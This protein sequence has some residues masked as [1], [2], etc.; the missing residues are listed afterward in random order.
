MPSDGTHFQLMRR[1][2]RRVEAEEG[3]DATTHRSPGRID[4]YAGRG[5]VRLDCKMRPEMGMR[6]ERV[7]AKPRVVRTRRASGVGTHAVHNR[8]GLRQRK[9]PLVSRKAR[10]Q[11]NAER[12][13][14]TC[15]RSGCSLTG[16]R[17]SRPADGVAPWTV[18]SSTV[19]EG[20]ESTR[21]RSLLGGAGGLI[22]ASN[23]RCSG[24]AHLHGDARLF[25][26]RRG[27]PAMRQEHCQQSR[28]FSGMPE[29]R[30]SHRKAVGD[31]LKKADDA[32]EKRPS[33]SFGWRGP[34]RSRRVVP[35][36]EEDK[37]R[38]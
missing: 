21:V 35:A 6:A 1:S 37:N 33:G 20:N 36:A 7:G 13:V 25:S 29:A 38:C 8:I 30:Q 22:D 5:A 28:E 11:M 4:A 3:Q 14:Q 12:L 16:T 24:A 17:R 10:H 26:Q 15:I 18:G 19:S 23:G 32:L 9:R 2:R 31:A 27:R 34:R